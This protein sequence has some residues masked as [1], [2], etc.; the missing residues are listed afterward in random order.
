MCAS[1]KTTDDPGNWKSSTGEKEK[2]SPEKATVISPDWNRRIKHGGREIWKKKMGLI[3]Y[4]EEFECSENY[5]FT[6]L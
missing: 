3:D 6:N 2:G 4:L 1:E 5:C